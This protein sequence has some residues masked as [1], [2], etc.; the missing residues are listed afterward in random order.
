MD[1]SGSGVFGVFGGFILD[2]VDFV[3]DTAECF[4]ILLDFLGELRSPLAQSYK[5][6]KFIKKNFHIKKSTLIF[7]Y[8]K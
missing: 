5:K 2:G 7:F 4:G 1:A 6:G 3:G 8:H